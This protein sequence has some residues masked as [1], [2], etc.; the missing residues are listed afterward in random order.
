MLNFNRLNGYNTMYHA[1]ILRIFQN[2]EHWTE[3]L[4]YFTAKL[5]QKINLELLH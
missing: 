2:K 3:L 1:N 5:Y 4:I